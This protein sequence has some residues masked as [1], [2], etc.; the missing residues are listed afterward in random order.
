MN[1]YLEGALGCVIM[2]ALAT[3]NAIGSIHT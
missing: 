3:E 1:H 2:Q